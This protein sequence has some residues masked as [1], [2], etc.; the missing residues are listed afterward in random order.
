M[1][2][3]G[4]FLSISLYSSNDF[5]L[6][7]L[8]NSYLSPKGSGQ[9]VFIV[10]SIIFQKAITF[11]DLF[12]LL[13]LDF[14]WASFSIVIHAFFYLY[15]SSVPTHLPSTSWKLFLSACHRN[16]TCFNYFMQFYSLRNKKSITLTF[17]IITRPFSLISVALFYD[18]MH[19]LLVIYFASVLYIIYAKF[20]TV[21]AYN[22]TWQFYRV[23]QG[24][25]WYTAVFFSFAVSSTLICF[26][27]LFFF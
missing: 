3:L 20:N 5:T 11:F 8:G 21:I 26:L 12:M 9:F 7:I 17:I 18:Q 2:N 23:L 15:S 13:L 16:G 1:G 19:E 10:S 24:L 14:A 6:Y 22:Q 4:G 25:V 27:T